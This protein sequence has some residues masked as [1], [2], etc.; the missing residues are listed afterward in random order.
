MKEVTSKDG[1]KIAVDVMGSGPP[2]VLVD[3]A[4]ASRATG[5]WSQVVGS[6]SKSFTTYHYDRRGRGSS[7]NSDTIDVQQEIDDLAAVCALAGSPPKVVG[8]NAGSV[9]ALRAA[10]A[11]VPM[12]RLLAWEVP[13]LIDGKRKVKT[14]ELRER[15]RTLIDANKRGEAMDLWYST[16]GAPGFGLAMM[17][18]FG[19][20]QAFEPNA[21]T[22]LRDFAVLGDTFNNGPLPDELKETFKRIKVPTTIGYGAW[23]ASWLKHS[24][25]V[26]AGLVP[27]A[28][29][30]TS[31]WMSQAFNPIQ[32]NRFLKSELGN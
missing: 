2:V 23:D 17:K 6:L 11:G 21:H 7:G 29:T 16:F 10:G 13:L 15:I 12:E 8:Y 32:M 31:W 25:K 1:T 14:P 3:P 20:M 30:R 22:L 26:V 9:L 4:L 19:I 27:G 28:V 24:A 18:A 5:M